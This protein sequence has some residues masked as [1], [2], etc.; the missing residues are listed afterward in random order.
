MAE[1]GAGGG[2]SDRFF[3]V[4]DDL[5]SY[6]TYLS[7]NKEKLVGLLSDLKTETSAITTGWADEDG[8]LFKEKFDKFISEAE[9]INTELETLSSFVTGESE[10]YS[11]ILADSLRIMDGG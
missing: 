2:S 11:S 1:S 7:E 3:A 9:K 10:I 8:K 6:A 5:D 4:T